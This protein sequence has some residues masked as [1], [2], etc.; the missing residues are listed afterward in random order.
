M[1]DSV[2]GSNPAP[3]SSSLF[4]FGPGCS[5]VNT[6]KVDL[7]LFHKKDLVMYNTES[8]A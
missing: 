7:D 3:L 5:N 6:V 8:S 1:S 4:S 2:G